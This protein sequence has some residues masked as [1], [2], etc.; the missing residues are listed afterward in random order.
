MA[1]R[2]RTARHRGRGQAPTAV[3]A[4]VS[5]RPAWNVA[6]RIRHRCPACG[7]LPE[8]ERYRDA[9]YASEVFLQRFGG[10]FQG[11]AGY[12]AYEPASPHHE[13]LALIVWMR[14]AF[15]ALRDALELLPDL[16]AEAGA[17]MPERLRQAIER[18]DVIGAVEALPPVDRALPALLR[19]DTLAG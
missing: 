16:Y 9:P 19:A 14:V 18:G 17:R 5:A 6:V 12:M 13:V 3:P 10:R 2:R 7:M 11:G 1:R 15:Q 8:A 4:T